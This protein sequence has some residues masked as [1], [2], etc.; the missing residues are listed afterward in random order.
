MS[1][2]PVRWR[3]PGEP[4]RPMAIHYPVSRELHRVFGRLGMLP[5]A[6]APL[7]PHEHGFR[8]LVQGSVPVILLGALGGMAAARCRRR[9]RFPRHR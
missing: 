8:E 9:R 5:M 6:D 3:Q 1:D 2:P 4:P 7:P